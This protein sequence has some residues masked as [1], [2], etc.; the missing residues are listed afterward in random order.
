MN[1]PSAIPREVQDALTHLGALDEELS[2]TDVDVELCLVGGVV[3][4]LVFDRSAG[5][6]RPSAM[7]G[8]RARLQAAER[9]VRQRL[10]LDAT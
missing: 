6:R 3:M 1:R 8:P 10:G 2:A 5:T 4:P 7:F 9:L